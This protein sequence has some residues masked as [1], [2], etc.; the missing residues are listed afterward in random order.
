MTIAQQKADLRL[1]AR[2]LRQKAHEAH[3]QE[4]ANAIATIAVGFLH[5]AC[6]L[7]GAGPP[8]LS[9]YASVGSEVDTGPLLKRL[10]EADMAL[11][12]PVTI[13]RGKPLLFRRWQPGDDMA[14]GFM[15]INEPLPS[16]PV[17]APD[18]LLVPLLAFDSD[19]YR[20]GYGGGHYDRTLVKLRAK[21]PIVAIG[22]AYDQQKIDAVPHD[23]YDQKLDWIVTPSGARSFGD[24]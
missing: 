1:S 4:A 14:R 23:C 6:Q 9:A 15:N 19:G 7:A 22:L 5:D 18:I 24:Q 17:V 3:G 16:A 10:H 8:I 2:Q 11:A 20:L 21:K 12:L 13:G